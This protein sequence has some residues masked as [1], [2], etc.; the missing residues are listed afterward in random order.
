MVEL[1]G[2]PEAVSGAVTLSKA[3]RDNVAGLSDRVVQLGTACEVEVVD[4]DPGAEIE[5]VRAAIE[6]A[7]ETLPGGNT[8]GTKAQIVVTGLWQI[9]SGMKM[10]TVKI[11]RAA[12]SLTAL[13]IGWTVAKVRPR[14]PEVL[15]CFR[16]HGFGHQSYKCSGPDL[17]G[18]CRKCGGEGHQEKNCEEPSG[19]VACDRLGFPYQPHKTGST[20]CLARRECDVDGG[21]GQMTTPL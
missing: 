21:D 8:E 19:C 6:N 7:M 11:P 10:A 9:R 13:K 5:D 20:S 18:K 15:R 2:G 4:L 14:R 17:C 16:C 3:V 1:A 12:A